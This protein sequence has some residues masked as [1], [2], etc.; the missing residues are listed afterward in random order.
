MIHEGNGTIWAYMSQSTGSKEAIKIGIL[1]ECLVSRLQYLPWYYVDIF[2]FLVSCTAKNITRACIDLAT[3]LISY[4]KESNLNLSLE[5]INIF[6]LWSN[7]SLMSVSDMGVLE[8]EVHDLGIQNTMGD[9]AAAS[10]VIALSLVL[11]VLTFSTLWN[12]QASQIHLG[13]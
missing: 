1:S 2:N 10:I 5:W 7:I 6:K 11:L 9:R 13:N 12:K 3:F 8:G 4:I